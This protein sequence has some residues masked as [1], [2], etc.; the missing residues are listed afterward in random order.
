MLV[1]SEPTD[2]GAGGQGSRGRGGGP[3]TLAIDTSLPAGSVAAVAGDRRAERALAAAA[4]HARLVSAHLAAVAADLG[5]R[6]ADAELVAVVRGPGSFTGLRVGV[7]T[8]KAIA[9]TTGCRLVAVSAFEVAAALAIR[10]AEADAAP[11]EIAF[12]AGRGEVYAATVVAAPESPVGWLV[13]PAA[14]R[15]AAE[16]VATLPDGAVVAGPAVVG[17][18]PLLAGRPGVGVAGV[19]AGSL[20]AVA[21]ARIAGLRLAAGTADDPATL[22]PEYLRPSYADERRAGG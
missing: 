6:V 13:G 18:G 11:L 22:V 2:G 12:D 21:A 19:D 8:A 7:T 9:W 5:W 3:R 20:P 10:P 14:L 16:W 17:L 1:Q 15:A 4:D